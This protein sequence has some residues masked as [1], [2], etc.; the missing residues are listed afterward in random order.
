MPCPTMQLI[1]GQPCVLQ[2]CV[3]RVKFLLMPQA[4]LFKLYELTAA[5][6]AACGEVDARLLELLAA[7]AGEV[8]AGSEQHI[9]W[10]RQFRWAIGV[11]C[12]L[13]VVEGWKISG[14]HCAGVSYCAC[15]ASIDKHY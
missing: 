9:F 14:D 3:V 12:A 2:A 15:P 5:A 4:S 7:L 8:C 1:L 6:V 13:C 11:P 10:A